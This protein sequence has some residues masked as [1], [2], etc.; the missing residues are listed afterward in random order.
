VS[1]R[2]HSGGIGDGGV[3]SPAPRASDAVGAARPSGAAPR[4]GAPLVR[5]PGEAGAE[6]SGE[7]ERPRESHAGPRLPLEVPSP[8]RVLFTVLDLSRTA[9]VEQHDEEIVHRYVDVLRD[10]FPARQFAVRLVSP[11][12]GELTVVYATGRLR[13]ETRDAVCV[14][15]AALTRHAIDGAPRGV[16]ASDQYVPLFEE[17]A[18]GFDV[19]LVDGERFLGT[20][21]IEYAPG[22]RPPLGDPPTIVPMVLQLAATLRNAQLFRESVYLRDY[23]GKLLENANAPILVVGRTRAIT[24]VNRAFLAV[25]GYT[26]ESLLGRDFLKLLPESERRR[27]LPVYIGALRGESSS[28]VEVSI[29]RAT[30]GAVRLSVNVASILSSDNEVEG[31]IAIG[32]DLTEVRDL[33]HQVIQAEKLATLGQLAAGVV[34][35]LNNPLTSI[36]VYA[37]HL[38]RKNERAGGD[39]T[40]TERLGRIIEAAQRILNFTRDLVTYARPSAEQPREISLQSVLDQSV[41]FCEHVILERGVTVEKRYAA[42]VPPVY[43]VRAQLHQVFINL[44]TNACQAMADGTGHLVLETSV[45]EPGGLVTVHVRDNGAGIP[46]ENVER[47]FEPFYT[48]KGE[49]K[50]TGLGLS[51]VR[52]ILHQ[53]RGEIS[54]ESAAGQGTTF[55]VK[56]LSKPDASP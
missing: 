13:G 37:E 16:V 47:V 25:T 11:D 54:V 26:R 32:R 17:G 50:G 19:P 29:P 1:K 6:E 24:V 44:I 56:L 5:A 14:S 49:G 48:T 55:T 46:A 41:V 28:N 51:I 42:G 43:A 27:L 12:T 53:H 31:V 21:A 10:L 2:D 52:N 30:T 23:L 7:I 38:L 18:E 45:S 3:T 22:A 20:V 15:R 39:P 9:F 8:D 33:E 40:D 36:T 35:E 4:A 34:H